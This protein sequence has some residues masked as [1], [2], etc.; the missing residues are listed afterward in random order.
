MGGS[1]SDRDQG[2]G[3]DGGGVVVCRYLLAPG[4][5]GDRR[6]DVR[7]ELVHLGR[8]VRAVFHHVVQP[9]HRFGV[10]V[11]THTRGYPRDMTDVRVAGLV[12]LAGMGAAR[13]RL[14]TAKGIDGTFS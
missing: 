1:G 7:G 13:E 3:S 14:G 8:E 6:T 9:G 12:D 5:A 2:D 4:E 11:A 10:G